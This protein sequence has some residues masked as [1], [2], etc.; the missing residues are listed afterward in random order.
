MQR[1]S[2]IKKTVYVE[3]KTSIYVKV[4]EITN[5]GCAVYQR[6][7]EHG[8]IIDSSILRASVDKFLDEYIEV[9][10]ISSPIIVG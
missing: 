10:D 8:S 2:K 9:V 5:A 6:C 4:T 1:K 3:R 7:D